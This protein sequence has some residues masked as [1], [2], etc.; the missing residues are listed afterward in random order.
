MSTRATYEFGGHTIYVHYDGYPSGAA[1][2]FLNMVRSYEQTGRVQLGGDA[3]GGYF[4]DFIRGNRLAVPS[5]GR[6]THGDTEYH[7]QL[8][9]NGELGVWRIS[10]EGWELFEQLKL[11]DFIT[12]ET[13]EVVSY[14]KKWGKTFVHTL[15]YFKLL[16]EQNHPSP[17]SFKFRELVK[18]IQ[19]EQSESVIHD[20]ATT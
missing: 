2:Y 1:V 15:P 14:F 19:D 10:V 17:E 8:H 9:E 6:D 5:E 13:G 12:R 3:S 16:S 18:T 20:Q 11:W 7:Y 4:Y